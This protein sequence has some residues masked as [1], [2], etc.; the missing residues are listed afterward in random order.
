MPA[1]SSADRG[2]KMPPTGNVPPQAGEDPHE[3]PRRDNA[4]SDQ[5]ATFLRTGLLVDVCGNAPCVT[6]DATRSNG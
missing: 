3:D 2:L 6:T 5:V 4:A 1:S